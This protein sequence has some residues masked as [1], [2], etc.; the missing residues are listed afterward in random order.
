V[1]TAHVIPVRVLHGYFDARQ[2][3]FLLLHPSVCFTERLGALGTAVTLAI[4]RGQLGGVA[5]ALEKIISMLFNFKDFFYSFVIFKKYKEVSFKMVF[6][7]I[8][9]LIKLN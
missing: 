5:V 1:S 7:N 9:K 6:R 8:N 2:I 3:C 4:N